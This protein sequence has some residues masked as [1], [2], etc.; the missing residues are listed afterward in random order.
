MKKRL[1]Y[2]I[3]KACVEFKGYTPDE[4]KKILA[5]LAKNTR[6]L[7]A[8]YRYHLHFKKEKVKMTV[9]LKKGGYTDDDDL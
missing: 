3:A 5:I 9:I 8:L 7:K 6:G 4:K 2:K 1:R